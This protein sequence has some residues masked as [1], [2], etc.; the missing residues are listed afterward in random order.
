M[1][2]T[3]DLP[4]NMTMNDPSKAF[5]DINHDILVKKL[6]FYGMRGIVKNWTVNYLSNRKQYVDLENNK[7]SI[8]YI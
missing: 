8:Q 7:S 1:E 5:A 3:S 6:D 4:H 2:K